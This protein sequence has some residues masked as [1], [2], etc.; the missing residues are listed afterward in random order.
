MAEH[1]EHSQH[2]VY[3]RERQLLL[4]VTLWLSGVVVDWTL[5]L[6][7]VDI[8]AHLLVDH[9][10]IHVFICVV[11]LCVW[12]RPQNYFNSEIFLIYGNCMCT[13]DLVVVSLVPRPHPTSVT[14]STEKQERVWYE[15]SILNVS[16]FFFFLTCSGQPPYWSEHTATEGSRL[17]MCR[18]PRGVPLRTVFPGQWESRNTRLQPSRGM[19][20]LLYNM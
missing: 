11:N 10:C 17:W 12:S 2:L 15:L 18:A 8:R 20:S 5:T 4:V 13:S 1:L 16:L 14:C 7:S 9:H 19:L 6:G 3:Y